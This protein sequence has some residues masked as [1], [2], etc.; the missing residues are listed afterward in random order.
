MC[1]SRK[2]GKINR[3]ELM[4]LHGEGKTDSE[5]AL[6]LNV[7]RRTVGMARERYGL[8]PNHPKGRPGS[9]EKIVITPQ[10]RKQVLRLLMQGYAPREVAIKSGISRKSVIEIYICNRPRYWPEMYKDLN[11]SQQ[12]QFQRWL[13]RLRLII[14]KK[15]QIHDIDLIK[16]QIQEIMDDIKEM[17]PENRGLLPSPKVMSR[18]GVK[19]SH[20]V[21]LTQDAEYVAF[22][23][24]IKLFQTIAEKKYW[25]DIR[26][27]MD[28]MDLETFKV[29]ERY[30]KEEVY[31][32]FFAGDFTGFISAKVGN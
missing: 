32:P 19:S 30:L 1:E 2:N 12:I 20:L 16:K 27:G 22:K 11:T 5:I 18:L 25:M 31:T 24:L 8:G 13:S 6:V 9:K 28:Q 21:Y 17:P 10:I 15:I 29:A 14:T 26:R 4:K 23:Q 7:S 3:E